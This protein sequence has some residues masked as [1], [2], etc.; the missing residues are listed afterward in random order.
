M[1]LIDE[2]FGGLSPDA[3]PPAMTNRFVWAISL[4]LTT[5]HLQCPDVTLRK[6]YWGP[7]HEAKIKFPRQCIQSQTHPGTKMDRIE[8]IQRTMVGSRRFTVSI[9]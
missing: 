7:V 9:A 5:C 1:T 3:A 2:V 8:Y 4:L 6:R